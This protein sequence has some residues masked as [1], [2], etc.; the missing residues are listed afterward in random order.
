MKPQEYVYAVL[1][2]AVNKSAFELPELPYISLERPKQEELGDLSTPLAMSLSKPLRM[3]PRKIA[4][5]LLQNLELDPDYIE[6]TEI[7]GPGFINFYYAKPCLQKAVLEIIRDGERYGCSDMGQGRKIQLEFVSANPTGPLNIVSARAAAVGDVLTSCYRTAGY[8]ARREFYV[9]D[10]GRQIRL[11]GVSLSA[12]YMTELG[13]PE[14]VPEEGY[15][16]AYLLDLAREIVARDG[17]RHGKL[18]ADDRAALF[19]QM[20]LEY[21]LQ[22]QKASLD[23]YRVVYDLWFRESTLREANAQ[24]HILRKM[25]DAGYTYE[26][27]G[28][29]WFRSS[30]FGDEKDR[31]LITQNGEPTYFLID[32]AYHQDKYE[33][34]FEKVIDFWGPDHHGYIDRMR[35]AV[36]ALGHPKESFEVSIIQQVNLLRSGQTVKMS[37]RAGEIIE[38]DEL[39]EEVGVDAARFYFVDRRISQPMDFDIDLAKKQSDENP[40]FYV[41]YAHA[42]ICNI[43]RYAEE[44][45][46]AVP[47][48]ADTSALGNAQEVQVIKKLLEFPDVVQR[49]VLNTEPHRI[50]NYVQEVA[51]AFHRFYHEHR[52]VTEDQSL[53]LARLM[54]AK[55]ARQVLANGF[56]LLGISAPENM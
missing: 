43:L 18:A 3:A 33:R 11:L 53:T 28:A 35:A 9:N 50:S 8:D 23:K 12:R 36:M 30:Q 16:G 29:L 22:R 24:E 26:H 52:V 17:D 10:A 6:K 2:K 49:V 34:G 37:K 21:M 19:S 46:V 25:A 38:M 47:E 54:L 41:Q 55:A 39:I 31:V 4:E 51:T 20:A 1:Q 32:V 15:H 27:E 14:E 45:G 56:K 42:R 48:A 44:Q 7:A 13:H 40:V 5:I